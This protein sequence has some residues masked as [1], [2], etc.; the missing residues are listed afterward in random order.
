MSCL[1]RSNLAVMI[2][3]HPRATCREPCFK[4]SKLSSNH[5]LEPSMPKSS[6]QHCFVRLP[7]SRPLADANE[8]KR[9]DGVGSGLG[10]IGPCTVSQNAQSAPTKAS[11]PLTR[12]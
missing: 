11:R 8:D 7:R 6:P 12:T 4:A 2:E 5:V 10:S 1:N 3:Q 9:S